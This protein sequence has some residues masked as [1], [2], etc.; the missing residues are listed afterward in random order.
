MQVNMSAMVSLTHQLLPTLKKQSKAYI[1]NVASTAAYQAVP[2]MAV[3]CASKAFVLNYTRS[4]RYE[5]KSIGISV[6]CVSPGPTTSNFTS[7]AG[8]QAMQAVADKFN[9][10]SEQVAKSA[11][12][13][14]FN[15][16]AEIIPG[17]VNWLTVYS[18]YLSP[19]SLVEKI[20]AGLYEKH[21]KR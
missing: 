1:L 10:P 7:R 2:T 13:G 19:K 18:T 5:L 21:L 9:M 17:L 12:D 6:S 11:I 8:M 14:L 15:H 20:A 16:K 3:Y 4:L